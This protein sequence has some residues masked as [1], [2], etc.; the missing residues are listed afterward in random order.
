MRE[1][2]AVQ[3]P[4]IAIA[5]VPQPETRPALLPPQPTTAEALRRVLAAEEFR[6]SFPS[7]PDAEERMSALF[8]LPSLCPDANRDTDL[9][10]STDFGERP[11][12]VDVR[13][14][15][16]LL[17][18]DGIEAGEVYGLGDDAIQIGRNSSNEIP[19]HDP[20]ISRVHARITRVDA[21]HVVE[22]LNSRNGT[23]VQGRRIA[24]AYLQDGDNIQLGPRVILRYSLVD[25]K[26]EQ[27]LR[28]LYESSKRDPL[29]GVYNRQ[30]FEERLNAE[31]SY[32]SR[33][34]ALLALLLLDLDHFKQVNDTH[35]HPTGDAV[36]KY[37]AA[38]VAQRLRT[39]DV[40][41]R[42][43][44]EEFT[45]ILR[46]S[47]LKG[48]VRVAERIRVAVATNPVHHEGKHIPVSVSIGCASLSCCTTPSAQA[49]IELADRRLYSAKNGG[50]NRVVYR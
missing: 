9:P 36:L 50:R 33:H 23:F 38:L 10:R 12:V 45:I 28:Q 49:L 22:D 24:R 6:R 2:A 41:A 35:G 14:R 26:Q 32:A 15:S 1:M 43:G 3:P 19:I 18:M 16:L 47:G 39:E 27:L 4:E 7:E 29:T 31:V 8:G 40:F 37:L 17:R 42:V 48:A 44:G 21:A 25:Q 5:A 11:A 46:G 34:K 20:G 13:D 30:H